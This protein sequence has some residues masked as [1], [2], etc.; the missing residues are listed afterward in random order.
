MI[1]ET[2]FSSEADT[3]NSRF[4][5]YCGLNIENTQN[6]SSIF[7]LLEKITIYSNLS[8]LREDSYNQVVE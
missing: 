1:P 8:K 3:L 4:L 7:F 6:K 2:G 5:N